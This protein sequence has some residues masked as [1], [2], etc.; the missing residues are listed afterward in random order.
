MSGLI[1]RADL[2]NLLAT[3]QTL[4]E[5]YAV[6]QGMEEVDAVQVVR[7][8]ECRYWDRLPSCSATPQYHACKRRIFADVHMTREDFCSQGERKESEANENH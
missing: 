3:A 4:T 5:A 8:G 2:F 6:I 1:R 7:C